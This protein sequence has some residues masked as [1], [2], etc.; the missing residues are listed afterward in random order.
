M[1]NGYIP[2]AA[3][4]VFVLLSPAWGLNCNLRIQVDHDGISRQIDGDSYNDGCYWQETFPGP[5][6]GPYY[7]YSVGVIDGGIWDITEPT[8]VIHYSPAVYACYNYFVGKKTTTLE[9]PAGTYTI[10]PLESPCSST[11]TMAVSIVPVTV[12]FTVLPEGA[13]TVTTDPPGP[14]YP[15]GTPVTVTAV[16]GEE[17]VFAVWRQY[18]YYSYTQNPYTFT[19]GYDDTL[20]AIF[21]ESKAKLTTG[22]QHTA[23]TVLDPRQSTRQAMALHADI[24]NKTTDV[25]SVTNLV[26]S[27]GGDLNAP[28]GI[29]LLD[30]AGCNGT[31]SELE[32]RSG[33]IGEQVAFSRAGDAITAQ[34]SRCYALRIDYPA[35]DLPFNKTV[36]AGIAPDGVTARTSSYQSAGVSGAAVSGKVVTGGPAITLTA[37]LDGSGDADRQIGT[38]LSG[39]SALNTF[40]ATITMKPE[41]FA[42]VDRVD[43]SIDDNRQEGVRVGTDNVFQAT[44]DMADF[45]AAVPVTV[46][47]TINTG[48][49]SMAVTE[50]YQL[51]A[52]PLP[53]WFDVLPAVSEAFTKTFDRDEKTYQA[54]FSYPIDFIWK[55]AVPGNVGLLGGL[56]N[57]LGVSFSAE[58]AFALD[59]SSQF[60]ASVSGTPTLLGHAFELQGG[61]KGSFD[62]AFAFAG[63]AGDVKARFEFELPEK[64]YART[65]LVYG[66]PITAAVDL[67]GN[68]A[69]FVDGN[70]VLDSDLRF[71]KA[72][73]IP[74][75]TVT[76]SLTVSLSAV[77]GLAK[78]AATGAP[79]VTLKI[80]MVY[81]AKDG[82][83]TTWNGEV[84]VPIKIVGSLFW[85][86]ASAE[87]YSDQLGPWQF[88]SGAAA[89][90]LSRS[91][92]ATTP[93]T[94]TTLTIPRLM[95]TQA[96][97]AGPDGR[98]I[99]VWIGD[100][101]PTAEKPNPDVFFRRLESGNWSTAAPL[102]GAAS[103]NSEWEMD[104]AV[105]FMNG[106]TAMAA[107]TTNAGEP[108]LTDLNDIFAA[109]DIAFARWDGS[110]W[111]APGRL[112]Q[113]AQ[114]DGTVALA[115]DADAQ[116]AV[117]V[118]LHDANSDH[119][120]ATRT[121]WRLDYAVF[122]EADGQWSSPAVVPGT[123]TGAADQM[124]AVAFDAAGSGLLLWAR[125]GD[126]VFFQSLGAVANGTNVSYENTDAE[127]M[128]SR[129][130]GTAWSAPAALTTTDAASDLFP[131]VAVIPSGGFAA[132][133]VKKDAAGAALYAAAFHDG[134]WS[135]PVQVHEGAIIESPA[136]LVDG[137]GQATVVWRGR[138]ELY[139]SSADMTAGDAGAWS[140]PTALSSGAATD[141]NPS[142]A[143]DGSNR[144]QVAWSKYDPTDKDTAATAGLSNGVCL[145]TAWPESAALTGAYTDA[146]V[147]ADGDGIAEGILIEVGVTVSESG[148]YTVQG[149]LFAG[150]TLIAPAQATRSGLSPGAA[151]FTLFF[152]GAIIADLNLTGPFQL[153]EISILN[154]ADA[155]MITDSASGT[156]TTTTDYSA[157]VFA[158]PPLAFDQGAYLGVDAIAAISLQ[159]AAANADPGAADTAVVTVTSTTD[160]NGTTVVLTETGFDT[161]LFTGRLLFQSP[162]SPPISGR[163]RV[164]GTDLLHARYTDPS[165]GYPWTTDAIW[166][167]RRFADVDLD[168]DVDLNDAMIVLRLLSGLDPQIDMAGYVAQQLSPDSP[169]PG[170]IEVIFALQ[171]AAGLH[172]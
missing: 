102:I 103:P 52:L 112:T 106:A 58:A 84:A 44:Y 119:D 144:L 166:R 80:R 28:A 94:A 132:V 31:Y 155:G 159:A 152:D 137:S 83:S 89:A 22:S 129:W 48:G 81:A 108:S 118:W 77:F 82:T 171:S 34:A 164:T 149:V 128:W 163:L 86:L 88:G 43:L 79:S 126:G 65:F 55:E 170:F 117:A 131:A 18:N 49:T 26:F 78:V 168:E 64:G 57:D 37:E 36:T 154:G 95:S 109:Q 123:D 93:S 30:D 133:W 13:G 160:S 100:T 153:K 143:L 91:A 158:A 23:E 40:T 14:G 97:A 3:A 24:R 85:G 73:V 101:T 5:D 122:N 7:V 147:D 113:D 63:G 116:N 165:T 134:A 125:D 161:G 142:I 151:V 60:G 59:T 21:Q 8:W 41:D 74:G 11:A 66:V 110:Q 111:S 51:A 107:W 16:A 172:P 90:A 69:L 72:T 148:D 115:Y 87:L 156:Y 167:A 138:K 136:L 9:D 139:A 53:G 92:M 96:L 121:Q 75:T 29:T 45:N 6:N 127:I 15:P 71:E 135:A 145:A 20:T 104:P 12:A 35:G 130:T 25:L 157:V 19:P 2:L 70:A 10:H 61:L 17:Y 76:G 46:T 62:E 54:G 47:V 38:F 56:G 162:A 1:R 32:T 4:L 169:K 39:I 124:P 146:S 150:G 140:A 105:V 141:L 68:V 27:L 114:A 50:T 99:Q 98:L 33:P 42:T 67:G 120:I